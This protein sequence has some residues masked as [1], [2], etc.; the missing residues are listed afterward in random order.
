MIL[1]RVVIEY[2]SRSKCV[3]ELQIVNGLRPLQV[4]AALQGEDDG[5]IIIHAE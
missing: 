4:T 5:T 1:E 3:K 2:L